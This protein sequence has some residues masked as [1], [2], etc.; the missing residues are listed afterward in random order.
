M[1]MVYL[2]VYI[3][4]MLL[5]TFLLH[6]SRNNQEF[7]NYVKLNIFTFNILSTYIINA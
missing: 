4:V 6:R 3:I 2:R 1:S 7:Q 5:Y